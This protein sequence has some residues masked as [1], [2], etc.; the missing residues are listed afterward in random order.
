MNVLGAS[1][2]AAD[3]DMKMTRKRNCQSEC[4]WKGPSSPNPT[5]A[6]WMYA[7]TILTTLAISFAWLAVICGGLTILA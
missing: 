1:M 6:Q 4:S 3:R 5:G 2:A 7:L